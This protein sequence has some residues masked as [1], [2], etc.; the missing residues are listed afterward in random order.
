M[1]D[2]AATLRAIDDELARYEALRTKSKHADLSDERM[3]LE[4]VVGRMADVLLNCAPYGGQ[5]WLTAIRSLVDHGRYAHICVHPLAGLLGDLKKDLARGDAPTIE[6]PNPQVVLLRELLMDLATWRSPGS[7]GDVKHLKAKER[8]N[9][10]AI[11]AKQLIKLAGAT[12]ETT[13]AK[14]GRGG[15]QPPEDIPVDAFDSVFYA[16][17]RH[18]EPHPAQRL[19]DAVR[20]ALGR[21]TQLA[22]GNQVVRVASAAPFDIEGAIVRALRPAFQG[23]PP[24]REREVQDA[25]EVILR[26]LAVDCTRDKESVIVGPRAFTPDFVVT[27][28]DLA[29]EVKLA[30]PKHLAGEIQ[31]EIAADVA[32]YSTKWK[33]SLFVI[34]DLGVI[35][36]PDR[37]REENMSKLGVMVLVI[38][39]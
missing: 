1:S 6:T 24:T 31:E 19:A 21:Y 18:G 26:T 35:H 36:D 5:I 23:G 7:W 27:G 17:D 8:I 33:R 30:T 29:I 39:H 12:T 13:V 9:A 22:S 14:A 34:Y 32:A 16:H 4:T 11:A 25:V 38:K 28:E 10:N 37:M 20:Q 3:E 2:N 15:R